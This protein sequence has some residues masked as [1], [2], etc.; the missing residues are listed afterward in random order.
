MLAALIE[1]MRPRQWTKNLILF[2]GVIF[3]QRIAHPADVEKALIAFLLF[4]GLSGVVYLVNDVMDAASDR[5]HPLKRNRPI[6]SGRLS[7]SVALVAALV[8][9]IICLAGSFALNLKFGIL[10]AVYLALSGSYSLATK[11]IVILDA[12]SVAL[13]FVIRAAA[14][15]EVIAVPISPWLLLCTLL[16]ALFLSLTK[17][18][19]EI[20]LLE[21]GAVSHRPI[22]AEYSTY[23]LDQMISVVT[24]ST[25]V[26]YSIYTLWPETVEKFH[27]PYL[28]LTI[29]CVIFGIFRY[30]YLVHQKNEGGRPERILSG[31]L[32]F[33]INLLVWLAIVVAVIYASPAFNM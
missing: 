29:P 31:D 33:I 1:T 8:L 20:L 17:R 25:V 9:G 15:A 23:L 12:M 21:N 27:T 13:G 4:C 24:A 16:L 5:Q 22:L 30:L 11:H 10:A 7:P 32:P 3:A 6:A 14:G 18:R 19:H 2:A 28:Y 26:C